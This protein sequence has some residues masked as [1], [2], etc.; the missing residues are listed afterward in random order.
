[1]KIINIIDGWFNNSHS[2]GAWC[3]DWRNTGSKL[4]TKFGIQLEK[5]PIRRV[6]AS[7]NGSSMRLFIMIDGKRHLLV[8]PSYF[9]TAIGLHGVES[10][11]GEDIFNCI[12]DY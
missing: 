2:T 12:T 4:K 7:N 9:H 8:N 10:L 1:M 11:K 6:Y 5:G 3:S